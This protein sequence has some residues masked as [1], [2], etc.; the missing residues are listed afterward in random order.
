MY[1]IDNFLDIKKE[2]YEYCSNLTF[3]RNNNVLVRH[4]DR[5][6]DLFQDVYIKCHEYLPTNKDVIVSKGMYTQIVKN[7]TFWVHAKKYNQKLNTNR[8]LCNMSYYQDSPKSEYLI[9]EVLC[10]DPKMFEELINS[11]DFKFYTSTLTTKEIQILK[12]SLKGFDMIDILKIYNITNKEFYLIFE[13]VSLTAIKFKSVEGLDLVEFKRRVINSNRYTRTKNTETIY[14][15]WANGKK[16]TEIAQE[17][18][19]SVGTVASTI[20]KIN[21]SKLK[22]AS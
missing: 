6:D 12:S 19:C 5:A 14:Y 20:F 10:E 7:L 15:S 17:L 18:N 8:I 3:T 21:K 2:I 16:Y 22:N 4:K 11:P 13:K 9:S 1:T